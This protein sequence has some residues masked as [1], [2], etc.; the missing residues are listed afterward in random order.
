M[1]IAKVEAY[2][3]THTH[4]IVNLCMCQT[5]KKA[6]IRRIADICAQNILHFYSLNLCTHISM[7]CEDVGA[8]AKIHIRG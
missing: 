1:S 6:Y 8:D 7:R 2:T 4:T 3:H 5:I